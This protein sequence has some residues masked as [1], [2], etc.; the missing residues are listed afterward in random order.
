MR[1]LLIN[2]NTTVAVTDRLHT[3]LQAFGAPHWQW[4]AVTASFGEPYIATE[5][6]YQVGVRA[7]L[8]AQA[9]HV[10]AHGLPDAVLVGC[11]G[12]PAVWA[13]RARHPGLPVMGLAEAAMREAVQHGPFGVVTGGHAWRPMLERLAAG[14]R[15]LGPRALVSV[16][17]VEATGGQLLSDWAAAQDTLLKAADEALTQTPSLRALVLGGA[18]LGGMA[19]DLADRVPCP[20]I[21]N[22]AAGGRWLAS[23]AAARRAGLP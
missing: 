8:E 2:P 4:H 15:L 13:L 19:A 17:T 7:V 21:D 23:V 12:D 3:Q 14:L 5:A 6:A 22:V 11:F 9:L 10:D 16:H 1:V 18:G 20:L